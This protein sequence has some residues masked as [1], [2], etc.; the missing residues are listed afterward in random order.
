CGFSSAI[1][2]R[3]RVRVSDGHL[4]EAEAPTETTV[5]TRKSESILTYGELFQR[6]HRQNSPKR[7]AN[8]PMNTGSYSLMA[9]SGST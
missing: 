9:E 1:L 8:Y 4:C 6:R 7:R 5:E 3:A 2:P